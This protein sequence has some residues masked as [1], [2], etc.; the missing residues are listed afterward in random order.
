MTALLQAYP[1]P[2]RFSFGDIVAEDG[3]LVCQYFSNPA[4]ANLIRTAPELLAELKALVADCEQ[5][6]SEAGD[7]D[8]RWLDAARAAI[9]KAELTNINTSKH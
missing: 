9:A 1:A 5:G 8:T 4:N 2:W 7:E 3:K 6:A